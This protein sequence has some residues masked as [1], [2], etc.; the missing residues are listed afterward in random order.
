VSP[1]A[2]LLAFALGSPQATTPALPLKKPSQD[3]AAPNVAPAASDTTKE[4]YD[5]LVKALDDANNT[6]NEH[7]SAAKDDAE[8]QKAFDE[9]YPNPDDW[10]PKFLALARECR[11]QPA[12]LEC[13]IWVVQRA[14][15]ADQKK[16][17]FEAAVAGHLDSPALER[18]VQPLGRY[19][20][21]ADG[22]K[23]L[24]V[25]LEKSPHRE[26]KAQ[27]TYALATTLVALA[28]Q[29][30]YVLKTV[31]ANRERALKQFGT[32]TIDEAES[33]DPDELRGESEDLLEDVISEYNELKG[34]VTQAKG[35]LFEI[36]NLAIGKVAPDIE[37]ADLDGVKFK[38]SDYR[39]KVVVVDFW[40]FW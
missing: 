24:R 25:V 18:L 22:E 13:Y 6:F 5:A 37:G 23:F 17:C 39:G 40:G 8:R 21:S 31:E 2:A 38:L 35:D 3:A 10:A 27:A 9:Y 12:A 7:Y 1:L 34:L 33:Q 32:A 14:R 11:G 19:N 29:R 16:E 15:S 20:A 4:R 36:R 26:V 28:E 30:D